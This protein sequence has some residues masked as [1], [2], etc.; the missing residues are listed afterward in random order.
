MIGLLKSDF[1]LFSETFANKYFDEDLGIDP[2]SRTCPICGNM[3]STHIA[4]F[5][6]RKSYRTFAYPWIWHN[7]QAALMESSRWV[8]VGY[9]LPDADFEF[10][11]LLKTAEL[12]FLRRRLAHSGF[13]DIV[14]VLKDDPSAEA[15]YRAFFG[16]RI[17][18]VIQGGL[19]EYVKLN[20]I[21]VGV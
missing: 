12:T 6:F 8:F 20:R 14:V 7:A 21:G 16:D 9:S 11:H 19:E 18:R 17:R 13:L 5:S 15:R 1:A 3:L 2:D 10:K 4:T